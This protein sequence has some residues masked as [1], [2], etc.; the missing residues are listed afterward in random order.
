MNAAY[1]HSMQATVERLQAERDEIAGVI[2]TSAKKTFFA[3]GD[4]NDLRLVTPETR[5]EFAVGIRE[6]KGQ[7]R[8]LETLGKPVVAAINGAAL[9]G[10]LE[11][12]LAATIAS[13]SMTRRPRSASPRSRSGCCPEPAASLARSA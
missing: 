5:R 4:L 9:G 11:I 1:V 2:I 6:I 7:L 13:S 3:G 12:A 8:A 10:G